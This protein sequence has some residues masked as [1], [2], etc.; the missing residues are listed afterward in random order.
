MLALREEKDNLAGNVM[1]QVPAS[2]VVSKWL[3]IFSLTID[4]ADKKFPN[5]PFS[6]RLTDW[7]S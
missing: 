5:S 2:G 4:Q 7:S 1:C 6:I 3:S